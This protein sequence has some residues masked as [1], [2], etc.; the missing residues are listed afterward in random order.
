MESNQWMVM[1]KEQKYDHN[2]D[3]YHSQKVHKTD[4]GIVNKKTTKK[5]EG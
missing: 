3:E 5:D 2:D 4:H 1:E